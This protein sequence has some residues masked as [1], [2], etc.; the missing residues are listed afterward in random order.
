MNFPLIFLHVFLLA[1]LGLSQI[2]PWLS[3]G[4]QDSGNS[5]P[6]PPPEDNGSPDEGIFSWLGGG[7]DS[8]S[9]DNGDASESSSSSS[10]NEDN[11]SA[12]EGSGEISNE[13]SNTYNGDVAIKETLQNPVPRPAGG[14]ITVTTEVEGTDEVFLIY[15]VNYGDENRIQM[16]RT[17]DGN[18]FA[19][20][21]AAED[22]RPG[23]M[24][25]WAVE[26]GNARDP[27]LP[28]GW[29]R[30]YYGTIVEDTNDKSNLPKVEL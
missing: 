21:I 18:L 13:S 24:I 20:V 9:N 7:G 11:S 19:A 4:S 23:N 2:F 30:K 15:V 6:S 8:E 12:N 3:G 1:G 22:A 26:A 17:G 28:G 10:N 14:P 25:R 5:S 27:V 29:N 16:E